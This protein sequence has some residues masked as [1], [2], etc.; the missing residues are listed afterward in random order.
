MLHPRHT[1]DNGKDLSILQDMIT[2]A[3][4][5]PITRPDWRSCCA[6]CRRNMRHNTIVRNAV[7]AKQGKYG[8]GSL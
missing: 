5:N 6:V 1:V 2:V 4:M 8:S 7:H 3:T